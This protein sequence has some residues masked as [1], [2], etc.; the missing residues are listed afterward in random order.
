M[1]DDIEVNIA[2]QAQTA[3]AQSGA[4]TTGPQMDTARAEAEI[5][6]LGEPRAEGEEGE[7][8]DTRS[9][10]PSGAQRLKRRNQALLAE[11][12][13][14]LRR[15][16]EVSHRGAADFAPRPEDFNGDA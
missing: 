3:P 10:R 9:K 14:L 15:L 4:E 8:E 1:N 5:E 11:N 13:E 6:G 16:D 7:A 12:A 2:E